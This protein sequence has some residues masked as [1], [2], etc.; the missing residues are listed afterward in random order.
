MTTNR[1]KMLRKAA[2]F[3][4]QRPAASLD[5]IATALTVSRATLHRHFAG[6][7]ALIAALRDVAVTELEAALTS[8]RL[9]EGSAIEALQR[10]VIACEPAAGYLV[11][12]YSQSRELDVEET[13]SFFNTL[14][15]AITTLFARG[16]QAGEFR[17]DL[18]AVWLTEAFYSLVTGGA[19][20]IQIGRVAG[21][22]FTHMI[23]SLLLQGI[24]VAAD[25]KRSP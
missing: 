16:Q 8:A 4:G 9:T 6:R 20:A 11:L 5:E 21:R 12:M 15:D 23:T 25:L 1:D 14:D 19:W 10:L 7:P 22:D 3:L 13:L 17:T 2:E 24:T 18:T